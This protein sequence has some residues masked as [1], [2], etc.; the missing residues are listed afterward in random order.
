MAARPS[1]RE[2]WQ[3]KILLTGGTGFVGSAVLR[4]LLLAGHEVRV[5]ARPG[6]NRRNLEGLDVDV[7][8]GDLCDAAS[9][10]SAIAGCTA[11]FHV[12]ANYRLWVRDA[13]ELYRHNLEG[14]RNVMLAAGRTGVERV[15]YTSSVATLG[16]NAD[17]SPANEDTPA[18]LDDMVGHYKRSKYLAEAEV[19]R[20]VAEGVVPAVIVNPSAPVGPRDTR[21]TPTGQMVLDA[22]AGNMPAY[23]DTG[24][25]IVH[26]DDVAEGHLLAFQRG[27]IGERYILGG[28]NLTLKAIF[29]QVCAISGSRAP[30]L[31]LPHSLVL[32]IAYAAEGWSRITGKEPRVTI[33]GIRLAR[34]KMFFAIDKATRELDYH[35]RPVALAFQ[36]AV[37]WYRENGYLRRGDAALER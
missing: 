15:V 23:V 32:P 25:N 30:R 13:T 31:R 3:M 36:D 35:P 8:T 16:V 4:R 9:I 7:V 12:A 22:A 34:K 33:D 6:S 26:V 20:L 14:T 5:V 28:T 2:K 17:G 27:R 29:S 18:A 21:P 11:L 10:A 37:R 1:T 19:S 24:L